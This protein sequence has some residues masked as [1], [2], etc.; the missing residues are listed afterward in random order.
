MN[1]IIP[2]SANIFILFFIIILGR[3]KSKRKFNFKFTGIHLLFGS[4][5]LFF[6]SFICCQFEYIK[7]AYSVNHNDFEFQKI[8]IICLLLTNTAILVLNKYYFYKKFNRQ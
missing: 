8:V 1:Y 3:I 4:W 5:L 2:L 6:G 7:N